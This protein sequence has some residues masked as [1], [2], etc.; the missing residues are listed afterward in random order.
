MDSLAKEDN[1]RDL[2]ESL[3]RLPEDLDKTYDDALERI[4]SQDSRKLARADQVLTL[5]SCAKRPL[6]LEEM[7]EALSIRRGD[8]FLDPEA[9]PKTE[10]LISTCCGLVVVED[11]SQIVRL[12]HYTTEEYFKRQLQHY[13]SSEAHRYVAGILVTYLSFTM[14]AN[15]SMDKKIEDAINKDE[16]GW[17][18]NRR[19]TVAGIVMRKLFK[20]SMLVQYAAEEWGNHARDAFANIGDIIQMLT[21]PLPFPTTAKGTTYGT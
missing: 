15:V 14:F 6:K 8:T 2:K 12:V 10:S 9:L 5:I 20:D 21:S 3:Q 7:L 1:I 4:K 13:R 18:W 11:E 16:E 19:G 17:S